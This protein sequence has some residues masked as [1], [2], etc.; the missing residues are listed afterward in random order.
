ME[1]NDTK[2]FYAFAVILAAIVI[3]VAAMFMIYFFI[4]FFLYIVAFAMVVF[5]G[6]KIYKLIKR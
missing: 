4:R 5:I 2:Y 6:Y 1:N 3:M